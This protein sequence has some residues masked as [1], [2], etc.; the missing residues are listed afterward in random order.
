MQISTTTAR[1]KLSDASRQ[2]GIPYQRLFLAVV[3]GAVPAERNGAGSR[4]L[5][6]ESDLPSIAK[7]L[8]LTH[9]QAHS[10]A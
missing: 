5:V 3:A 2:L 8:G 7:T 4:W 9:T 1:L 6:K 10:A